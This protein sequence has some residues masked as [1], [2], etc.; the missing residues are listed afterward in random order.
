MLSEAKHLL[1]CPANASTALAGALKIKA[2]SS[3]AQNRHKLRMTRTE[4][5]SSLLG[6]YPLS[7]FFPVVVIPL[8]PG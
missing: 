7:M 2:D 8:T 4:V 5:F 6:V 3:L 1:F